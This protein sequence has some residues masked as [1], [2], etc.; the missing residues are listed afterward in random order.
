MRLLLTLKYFYAADK[1]CKIKCCYARR[2][3][4]WAWLIKLYMMIFSHC[5]VVVKY[6]IGAA[7]LTLP[8]SIIA[9]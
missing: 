9:G 3:I 4:A 2:Y 5:F 1:V 6:E 8:A 7:N